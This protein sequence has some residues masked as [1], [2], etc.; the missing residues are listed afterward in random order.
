MLEL[1]TKLKDQT[2]AEAKEK[3]EQ[4]LADAET[5]AKERLGELEKEQ[6]SLTNRVDALRKTVA[7]YRERFESLLQAQQ[8]AMDKISDL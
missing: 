8:E 1:A 5:K 6:E 4:I 3:A 7:D 2:I